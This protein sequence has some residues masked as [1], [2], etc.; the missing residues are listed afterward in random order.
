MI[1]H[2]NKKGD[3]MNNFAYEYFDLEL[4]QSDNFLDILDICLE[5]NKRS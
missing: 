5:K 2:K 3:K 4:L 1:I